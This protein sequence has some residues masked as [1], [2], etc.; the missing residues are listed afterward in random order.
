MEIIPLPTLGPSTVALTRRDTA[1][2]PAQGNNT[3]LTVTPIETPAVQVV[4]RQEPVA[5][6]VYTESSTS[7]YRLRDESAAGP[8]RQTTAQALL[9]SLNNASQKKSPFSVSSVFSQIPALSRETSEYRNE[10]R[11]FKVPAKMRAENLSPDFSTTKGTK[12]EGVS[13]N[14]RTKDGDTVLIQMNRIRYADGSDGIEFSFVV[15]G[16]L[17][18][19]E[20]EALAQLTNKLGEVSDT[21]FRRGTSLL[22]GLEEVDKGVIAGFSLQLQRPQGDS[23]ET[24][25]YDY[26]VDA[27]AGTHS[28]QAQD[29]NGYEVSITSALGEGLRGKGVAARDA[30]GDYLELIRQAADDN[31]VPSSSQQFLTDAFASLLSLDVAAEEE[32][33]VLANTDLSPQGSEAAFVSG[34]PDFTAT[35]RSPVIHNRQNY[36]QVSAMVLTLSQETTREA[37]E[38]GRLIKQDSHYALSS[39]RFEPLPGLEY[40]D[41]V[42]GNYQYMKEK[43]EATT[44]RILS[45]TGDRVADVW[46]AQDMETATQRQRFESYQ[47]TDEDHHQDSQRQLDSLAPQLEALYRH[48]QGVAI[49]ALLVLR[50]ERLF[51]GL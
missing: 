4:L 24:L 42:S 20:Q 15:D 8:A 26:R 29:A 27:A 46:T 21:F 50:P 33:A 3:S 34:L 43:T 45:L 19:R 41:V 1:T 18:E 7:V 35:F 51:V 14:I 40:P 16:S 5:A 37:H 13:L 6:P 31:G 17:S 38:T 36:T 49:E 22:G 44:S 39:S 28:L 25:S 10:A 47:L 23:L 9:S 48:K 2:L 32:E 12:A 11:Q 30:L